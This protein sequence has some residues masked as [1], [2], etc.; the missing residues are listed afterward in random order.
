MCICN[1]INS[2]LDLTNICLEIVCKADKLPSKLE[3]KM[4]QFENFQGWTF[5][6]NK[7][8]LHFVGVIFGFVD[9][10]CMI[11]SMFFLR[12]LVCK[13]FRLSCVSDIL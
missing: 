8:F 9:R 5:K 2:V 6:Q 13:L 3:I 11:L 1:R 12:Y 7:K 4:R 10:F